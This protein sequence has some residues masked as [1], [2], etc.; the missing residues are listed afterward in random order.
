PLA[1]ALRLASVMPTLVA[2][3]WR[4]R[5]GH[6]PIV[7][8]PTLGHVANYLWM[9]EGV[10]PIPE[11]VRGLERYLILT[12]EHGMN[13][14]TFTARVIAS[15]GA[16]VVAAVTGAAGAFAGPLH[17]GA[18]S[19]VLEMLDA[20]GTAERAEGWIHDTL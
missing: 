11:R 17:G 5:T 14:S 2:A 20:I 4:I 18:P 7:A 15:T 1:V 9:L 6:A 8:D 3:L 10:R 19:H 16:D 13:A 12:A